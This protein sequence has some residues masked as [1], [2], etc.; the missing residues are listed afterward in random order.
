[1]CS[2]QCKVDKV[3]HIGAGADEP[4]VLLIFLRLNPLPAWH[5]CRSNP[6]SP[7]PSSKSKTL[8]WTKRS[9]SASPRSPLHWPHWRKN[10]S[11]HSISASYLQETRNKQIM[12]PFQKVSTYYKDYSFQNF[13]WKQQIL[14]YCVVLWQCVWTDNSGKSKYSLGIGSLPLD[15]SANL[16]PA[17]HN[18]IKIQSGAYN[19]HPLLPCDT[20]IWRLNAHFASNLLVIGNNLF[21]LH[22]SWQL[23][24]HRIPA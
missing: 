7:E 18:P 11:F 12:F 23:W 8:L 4:P 1:M 6:V 10:T 5:P 2:A 22:K 14:L 19:I 16:I 24:E 21:W 13:N 3:R 17:N 20:L 9:G 15:L